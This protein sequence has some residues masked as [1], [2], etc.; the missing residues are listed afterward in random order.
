MKKEKEINE[1][2]LDLLRELDMDDLKIEKEW[3]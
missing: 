1:I 2:R 3:G